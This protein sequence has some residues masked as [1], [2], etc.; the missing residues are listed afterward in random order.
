MNISDFKKQDLT[1]RV[2]QRILRFI[3]AVEDKEADDQ[4]IDEQNG[5]IN[6][7]LLEVDSDTR[8]FEEHLRERIKDIVREVIDETI[9]QLSEVLEA[10]KKAQSVTVIPKADFNKEKE[11][12][13]LCYD[14]TA[15]QG[16]A[17]YIVN[18]VYVCS[19]FNAEL[20]LN[21][22]RSN[23]GKLK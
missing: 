10:I 19:K 9:G 4:F 14:P 17:G 11:K 15:A 18:P 8:A 5:N 3:K 13:T 6:E 2:N 21:I 16:T 1:Y 23:D 7:A 12:Y 20:N 22:E